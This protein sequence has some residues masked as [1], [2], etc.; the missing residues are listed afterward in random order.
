MKPIRIFNDI[1]TDY[2]RVYFSCFRDI[3]ENTSYSRPPEY[4]FMI[5]TVSNGMVKKHSYDIAEN[6]PELKAYIKISSY[7]KLLEVEKELTDWLVSLYNATN[8]TII[9]LPRKDLTEYVESKLKIKYKVILVQH[10]KVKGTAILKPV[11]GHIIL[12]ELDTNIVHIFW[13]GLDCSYSDKSYKDRMRALFNYINNEI[14]DC[15]NWIDDSQINV[16]AYNS[17]EHLFKGMVVSKAVT[18]FH[19]IGDAKGIDIS[20]LPYQH[21]ITSFDE[22]EKLTEL[23]KQISKDRKSTKGQSLWKSLKYQTKED[24][25][26]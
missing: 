22:P 1:Y 4:D 7:M 18:K 5:E 9:D 21:Q 17:Y 20:K 8:S 2:Q 14:G 11:P 23:Y 15:G 3:S 16:E 19:N 25:S 6:N 10:S 26:L 12:R 24:N 13:D